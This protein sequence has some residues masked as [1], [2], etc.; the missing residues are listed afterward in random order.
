MYGTDGTD[1]VVQIGL[2]NWRD[3]LTL[4]SDGIT[5][6][7]NRTPNMSGLI[8]QSLSMS[9]YVGNPTGIPG[10]YDDMQWGRFFQTSGSTT[11]FAPAFEQGQMM[12][13]RVDQTTLGDRTDNPNYRRIFV[14]LSDG[15]PT[16]PDGFNNINFIDCNAFCDGSP[17]NGAV[18]LNNGSDCG[19]AV[20]EANWQSQGVN[21]SGN[22]VNMFPYC[23]Q[24]ERFQLNMNSNLPQNE[25]GFPPNA[26]QAAGIG[27]VSSTT[28]GI[29]CPPALPAGDDCCGLMY[30]FT[31]VIQNAFYRLIANEPEGVWGL[32]PSLN[33]S[34]NCDTCWSNLMGPSQTQIFAQ[35]IANDVLCVLPSCTCPTGYVRVTTP[36]SM[37][38][39]PYVPTQIGDPLLYCDS[40][41]GS[42]NNGVCRRLSCD[43]NV[44]NIT[45]SIVEG[46]YFETGRCDDT[47]SNAVADYYAQSIVFP[48]INLGDPNY[49]NTDPLMCNY[50]TLCCI[51]PSYDKG[52]IWKHNDRCDLFTNYY[53]KDYPWEVEI[54]ESSGQTVNTVRSVEYQLE[55]YIYNGNLNND[56]GDRF[57]D[58]DFNFDEVIIHNTE[59][60]SGLLRLNLSPKN[61]A[62]LIT[63]FPIISGNDIQ[64]L[65]SKEEQKYRFNQFWDIT[66][67]RGEFTQSSQSIFI[68]ELNGYIRELNQANLNYFKPA[69]QHKKFR[70]YWNKVIFRRISSRNR[71]MILKLTNTKIN[72]SFR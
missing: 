67:D 32:D 21:A 68:T 4:D 10:Q 26:A 34:M 41:E 28:Y 2:H 42:I 23:G 18:G 66:K 64:I 1:G 49:F 44:E 61:D 39:D 13:S 58:L 47:I 37:A 55:S 43:C 29:F 65:Y 71:K 45:D 51:G 8:D 53:D 36:N 72:A 7:C 62:P 52:G 54:V 6:N 17:L 24:G 12:L 27:S 57:H 15:L 33:F 3:G 25:Y 14:F 63:D 5:G 30:P 19:A 40:P 11:N 50:D 35:N 60:V 16:V 59:Q 20:N 9:N 31:Q 22:N 38:P 70:H 69:F 48:D 56:C 46:S